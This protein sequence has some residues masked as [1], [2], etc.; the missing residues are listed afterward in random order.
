MKSMHEHII[1]LHVKKIADLLSKFQFTC[2]IDEH[3]WQEYS[4]KLMFLDKNEHLGH[5]RLYYA[6]SKKSFRFDARY[7]HNE[8]IVGLIGGST[9]Q[10]VSEK[11]KEHSE[12]YSHH[13]GL[14]AYVDGSYIKGKI[15]FGFVILLDNNKVFEDQGKVSNP[16]YQDARQ[17]AGELTAVGKVI[18]WCITHNHTS[19]TIYYDYAGIEAW[20]TGTWRAKQPLTQRYAAFVKNSGIS[21]HW[22]KVAAH[23]GNYWNDY[24]DELAKKGTK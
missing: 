1:R 23:T 4:V 15:G 21:V 3:S 11:K 19:I 20:V 16:E 6:P 10:S 7:I 2:S 5:A 13:T 14:S 8:D 22:K 9:Q 18:Q 24:V 12:K 17:V